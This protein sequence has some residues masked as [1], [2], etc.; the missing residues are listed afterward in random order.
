[1]LD[2]LKTSKTSTIGEK[3]SKYLIV[4]PIILSKY[5]LGLG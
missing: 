3:L 2:E 4:K 1:M 5:K